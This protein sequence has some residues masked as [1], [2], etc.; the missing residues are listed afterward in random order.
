M[1]IRY[2]IL[3]LPLM[4]CSCVSQS[5]YL[6]HHSLGYVHVDRGDGSGRVVRKDERCDF[7]SD[8]FGAKPWI[9]NGRRYPAPPTPDSVPSMYTHL[10]WDIF[11]W[12]RSYCLF[13][14]QSKSLYL[15]PRLKNEWQVENYDKVQP[16]GFP[17]RPMKKES[18][19]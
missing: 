6:Q 2:I 15:L 19:N 7:D 12:S 8:L 10:E 18:N 17:L 13:L 16:D 11:S 5:V 14:D 9:V 1:I 3:L 4:L